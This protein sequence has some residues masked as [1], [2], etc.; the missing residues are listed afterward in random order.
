M[1]SY[2]KPFSPFGGNCNLPNTFPSNDLIVPSG[3]AIVNAQQKKSLKQFFFF[4]FID[5][6]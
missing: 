1:G 4:T 3:R 6:K 5:F 2:P